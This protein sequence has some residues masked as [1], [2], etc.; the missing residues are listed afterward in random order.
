MP[1]A[2]W[3]GVEKP[4]ATCYLDPAILILKPKTEKCDTHESTYFA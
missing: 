4:A 2:L 3:K 1:Y